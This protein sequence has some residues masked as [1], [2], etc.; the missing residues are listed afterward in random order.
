MSKPS[1][2]KNTKLDV[3]PEKKKTDNKFSVLCM[4]E[5][6][7]IVLENPVNLIDKNEKIFDYTGS[8]KHK[9]TAT[10]FEQSR[11]KVMKNRVS[12]DTT[13]T[14]F[15]VDCVML[16]ETNDDKPDEYLNETR[17]SKM[18]MEKNRNCDK[19]LSGSTRLDT[20]KFSKEIQK[21]ILS[22]T[23]LCK[24][25]EV[26]NSASLGKTP[27]VFNSASLGKT[28]EVFN[29][30]TLGKTPEV[31]NS[32]TLSKT[33]ETGGSYFGNNKV[34]NE[35]S[36]MS[37]NDWTFG[38]QKK[39]KKRTDKQEDDMKTDQSKKELYI[40]NNDTNNI[41][42]NNLFLNSQ[43]TVWVHKSDCPIWTE[44]SYTNIYLINNIGSF[45]R[46]F[47][48]FHLLDKVK[49]QLFIM[50]NKIKPIWEDNDNRNGGICSIKIDCY[51]HRNYDSTDIGCD[52]MT[53]I[54]LLVMNETFIQNTDEI[55][56][57]SYSIKNKSILIKL[58]CKNFNVKIIDRLPFTFFDKLDNI[59]KNSGG[60]FNRSSHS[61]ARKND[62]KLSIRYIKI[63]PEY[64]LSN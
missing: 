47:N 24:T 62:N 3:F 18:S 21:T 29:S 6:E 11:S 54:S 60:E 33:P 43:W 12:S 49:N 5:D 35:S 53:C 32:A 2:K 41:L 48:N 36:G 31:F 23:E 4:D 34:N 19:F 57:I 40:E 28:P 46:F 50:R 45:W 58:W 56:G 25:P 64:E 17:V 44:H 15:S 63:E 37:H 27:E 30:A 9:K 14:Q 10:R 55:N 51:G 39:Q 20:T 42:G 38:G 61:Y 26:F 22:E 16:R 52:V 1:N 13:P 8:E 59:L 7:D